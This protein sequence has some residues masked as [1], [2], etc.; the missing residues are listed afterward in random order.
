MT[1]SSDNL[2][3]KLPIDLGLILELQQLGIKHNPEKI[4]QIAKLYDGK[5]IFLETGNTNSGLE[6]ILENHGDEFAQNGINE[7]EV[8]EAVITAVTQGKIVGYQ[9]PNRPIYELIFK[10]KMQRIAVTVG[11][12]GYIVCANPRSNR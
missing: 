6:H 11:S 2:K 12:N 7:I 8:G 4:I 3:P 1:N 10:N 9:K 5:I